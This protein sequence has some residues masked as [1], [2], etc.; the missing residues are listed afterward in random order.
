MKVLQVI[1]S[2]R[3]GGSESL[4]ATLAEQ[5]SRRGV[6]SHICGL[7]GDGPLRN[8]LEAV[9]IGASHLDAHTGVKP[10][11]MLALMRLAWRERS[12]VILTHHFRQLVHAAPA[13]FLLRNRLIHVEHDYHSY[14]E[15]PDILKRFGQFA[16]VVHRFVFVSKD[17]RDWFAERLPR[18]TAKC[19]AIPNGIDTDRFSRNETDRKAL[20]QQLEVTDD[21]IVVGTCARLEPVKD[22]GLLLDGFKFFKARSKI[23]CHLLLVGDGSLRS[24][25]E[26]QAEKNGIAQQSHF[27][28]VVDNVHQWLSAMDIYAITSLDEG[29]P[30]AVKEAMS[31]RLPVVATDVG[32][33]DE[34]V[35][36]DTGI[37]LRD[38]TPEGLGEALDRLC[39]DRA[40]IAAL[41]EQAR[42]DAISRYSVHRMT[43]TYLSLMPEP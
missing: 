12:D 39:R 37:I 20:R 3:L 13:A 35:S 5:F 15:R 33:L 27:V 41:G 4:A 29:L 10:G 19:V 6:E 26:Y 34:M 36:R 1:D 21:A 18:H 28:G 7:G 42:L 24:R 11:A 32:S 23:P 43:E 9:G 14:E 30:L 17:I 2:L 38:R 31:C 8:R 25:L 22:L 16:P 40:A